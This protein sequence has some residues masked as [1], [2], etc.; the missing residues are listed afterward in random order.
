MVIVLHIITGK[1]VVVLK[2]LLIILHK[3]TY[4]LDSLL[5]TELQGVVVLV[6]ASERRTVDEDDAVLH[7]RLGSHQLVVGGVV[8]HI[9]NT[10]L[11]GAVCK[12]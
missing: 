4:Q 9:D 3:H 10:G 1:V 11:A 8:H 12:E 2:L 7:Q 6:P 5:A